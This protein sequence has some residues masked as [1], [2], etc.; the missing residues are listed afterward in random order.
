MKSEL[1]IN[2]ILNDWFDRCVSTYIQD[3][4][5]PQNWTLVL[6]CAADRSSCLQPSDI[7]TKAVNSVTGMDEDCLFLNV[8]TPQVHLSLL[9]STETAGQSLQRFRD[10]MY[11]VYASQYGCAVIFLESPKIQ[12]LVA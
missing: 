2:L 7:F 5:P 10:Q 6:N 11:T 3:P 1:G 12:R 8:Y 4:E 9:L